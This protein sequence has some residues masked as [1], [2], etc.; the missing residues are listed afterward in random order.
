[1]RAMR[2]NGAYQLDQSELRKLETPYKRLTFAGGGNI[3]KRLAR[4][5]EK[6]YQV[7]LIEKNKARAESIAEDLP[8]TIVLHGDVADEDLLLEESVENTDVFCT[9]T[10]DDEDKSIRQTTHQ[11]ERS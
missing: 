1:M 5:L 10:N 9:I 2:D 7:K 6:R 11:C 4:A 3:G 8:K